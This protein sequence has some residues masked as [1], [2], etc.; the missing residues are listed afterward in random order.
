MRSTLL[1]ICCFLALYVDAQY[2]IDTIDVSVSQVP[3]KISE[4]GRN[5][6]ILT[7]EDLAAIPATSIDEM[8][9]T[10][11][12]LEVQSRGGFGT[13]GDILLRGSTFT[14]V[15]MLIDGMKM[16]DPLTGHFNSNIPVTPAEIERIEIYRGAAAAMYGADAVGGVINIVT[17]TFSANTQ[18]ENKQ[19]GSLSYGEHEFVRGQYGF[20][21]RGENWS[22][23]AGIAVSQSEGEAYPEKVIDSTMTLDAYN[24]FFDIKTLG[25]SAAYRFSEGLAIR[26]RT[27]YDH[28]DF[29]ARYYYTTSP[30]DKSTEV[31]SNWYNHLQLARVATASSTDVNFAYKNN[32]DEFV[33][34][35][36]FSS[37][38]NHTTEF[39]NLTINHLQELSSKVTLKIGAQADQRKIDS[40]DRG[41]HDNYHFG[42]YAMGVYQQAGLN[43]T[44]SLRSDYDDNYELEFS[45][46]ANVSYVLPSMVLRGSIGR[47]IRAADY[48][49]RFVSNN[50]TNLTPGRSLGNPDLLAERSWSEELGLDYF[51]NSNWTIKSTAFARQST[52]LIDYILTNEAD[53]GRISES[54]SLQERADYFFAQNIS[55]VSTLGFELESELRISLSGRAHL[56]WNIGYTYLDTTNDE[57]TVSVYISSHAKQLFTTR[58]RFE[59]ER[60]E[61]GISGLYK[62]RE[63][64]VATAISSEL[65]DSYSLWNVRLGLPI[66]A[67]FGLNLQVQNLFDTAYQNILGAQMP[68]RWIMGGISWSL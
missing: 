43:L 8:L 12:G 28:R 21:K 62:Q 68:S 17:K 65:G 34:S 46:Q 16:N 22:L 45:P 15:M 36:D 35:P 25:A 61:L 5:I 7:A 6:T 39:L 31:V 20:N 42:L 19:S 3:L 56:L 53:I 4:T 37:T 58:L 18:I 49:E 44:L 11:P 1:I 59:H 29:D 26:F 14:Q 64:R 2:Q 38:N 27:A 54:G 9:Q 66:T 13:Q 52:N 32:S 10:V 67:D 30:F 50:L 57:E 63:G 33:F 51:V 55:A 48:T 60:F 40:N 23:G 24:S 47:S 41:M